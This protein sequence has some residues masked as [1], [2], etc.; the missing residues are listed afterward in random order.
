MF[1]ITILNIIIFITVDNL[2]ILFLFIILLFLGTKY[3]H[4]RWLNLDTNTN[5]MN[6]ST[7]YLY[8][9]INASNNSTTVMG[10]VP[11]I[12]VRGGPINSKN[13]L[14]KDGREIYLDILA[15]TAL[16]TFQGMFRAF[17]MFYYFYCVSFYYWFLIF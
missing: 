2:L 9:T 8:S 12:R 6:S 16:L 11:R 3:C 7:N 15:A 14:E 17:L 13:E 10:N 5:Y 4:T 1:M